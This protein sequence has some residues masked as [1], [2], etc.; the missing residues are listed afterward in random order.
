MSYVCIG[1]LNKVNVL[2]QNQSKVKIKSEDRASRTSVMKKL[3]SAVCHLRSDTE[4]LV[5]LAL[6]VFY[7]I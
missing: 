4:V 1:K 2:I 3:S 6:F 7:A 5:Q